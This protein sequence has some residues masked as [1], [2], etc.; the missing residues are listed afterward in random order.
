M[1]KFFL[2][3]FIMTSLALEKKRS[4]RYNGKMGS[5]PLFSIIT[6][7]YNNKEGLKKTIDSVAAQTFGGY[8]HI[9]ID[10]GSTDGSVDVINAA[11][12]DKEYAARVPYWQSKKDGGIYPAMNVGVERAEGL[13][14]LM[15][16]SGDWLASPSV[17]ERAAAFGFDEDI[18]YCDA[19]FA[20]KGRLRR[21][22]YPKK[23]K[24]YF[25]FLRGFCHQTTFIKT[26]L[27]KKNP[28]STEYK[29]VNDSD[30]FMKVLLVQN[31]STRH[32]P[33]ALSV[34]D[35]E[36]G[37]SSANAALQDK[38]YAALLDKYY[39]RRVQEDLLWRMRREQWLLLLYRKVK[40]TIL[41]ILKRR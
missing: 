12:Q 35:A 37:L 3:Y 31:C 27:Q 25:F 30:F 21:I 39:P 9:I 16:N 8:E 29:I 28:Y 34:Y 7:N 40:R 24:G 17:L 19:L 4:A 38:E 32:L 1:R 36:G 13:Y 11:L 20:M 33:M 5:A 6:I 10:G 26:S 14:C 2:F 15:L 23:I 18:V 41:S 22:R